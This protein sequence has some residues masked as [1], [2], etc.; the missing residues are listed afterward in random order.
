M[1]R[2]APGTTIY[3]SAYSTYLCVVMQVEA[4]E[5]H[6]HTSTCVLTLL[7]MCRHAGGGAG[8]APRHAG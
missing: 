4:L 1:C 5:K 7:F 6:P 3:V 8:E 2:H